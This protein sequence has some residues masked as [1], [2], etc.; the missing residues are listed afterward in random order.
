MMGSQ[1]TGQIPCADAS[2][3]VKPWRKSTV[4]GDTTIA[5]M[6]SQC[7][8][9]NIDISHCANP[10]FTRDRGA[11]QRLALHPTKLA[12]PC[13]EFMR[14][15]DM[16]DAIFKLA[17][18]LGQFC[19]HQAKPKRSNEPPG[20]GISDALAENELMGHVTWAD[21]APGLHHWWS[22]G[23]IGRHGVNQIPT[24]QL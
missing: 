3:Q 20:W 7:R 9:P 18:T 1:F 12:F 11:L 4:T 19:D 21:T 6:S 24:L 14:S 2:D 23:T 15:V 5:A 22:I 16:F 8:R 17:V 10:H 13:G